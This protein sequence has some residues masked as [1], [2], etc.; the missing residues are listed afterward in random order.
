MSNL[1]LQLYRM[2]FTNIINIFTPLHI[3]VCTTAVDNSSSE[4]QKGLALPP[5]VALIHTGPI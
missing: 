2:N 3:T 5:I 1:D 4:Q